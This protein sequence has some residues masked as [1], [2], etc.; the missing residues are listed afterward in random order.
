MGVS[1]V[2]VVVAVFIFAAVV[3]SSQVE[4]FIDRLGSTF[5]A[6]YLGVFYFLFCMTATAYVKVTCTSPGRPQDLLEGGAAAPYMDMGRDAKEKHMRVCN[7]C[8]CNKPERC[9]HCSDCNACTLKMDHHCPWVNNCV[10]FR[11][12]KFFYL[13]LLYGTLTELMCLGLLIYSLV[14]RDAW[15]TWDYVSCACVGIVGLFALGTVGLWVF[16][17]S[18][19]LVNQTTIEQLQSVSSETY[20]LGARNNVRQVLGGNPLIWLIP[21][22][23]GVPDAEFDGVNWD[24]PRQRPA[25]APV[26]K[27]PANG[28]GNGNEVS[29]DAIEIQVTGPAGA[30]LS[31]PPPPMYAVDGSGLGVQAH[32]GAPPIVG[33]INPDQS[34]IEQRIA[35][36]YAA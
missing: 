36:S 7:R 25:L 6:I 19:L 27:P 3:V 18:L 17:T 22:V 31:S 4:E 14:E 32:V 15:E 26:P 24:D 10:G 29:S 5:T 16:H 11:N 21:C 35:P 2:V 20:S 34:S 30:T 9:H 12:Y 28:N 33:D 8:K 23:W 1:H 13:L